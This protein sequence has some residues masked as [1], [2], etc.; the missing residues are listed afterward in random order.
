M[1]GLQ[2]HYGLEL[3]EKV[4]TELPSCPIVWG[5]VH[6]SLL[7][8]QTTASPY[9]DIVVRGEGEPVMAKLANNLSAGNRLDYVAGITY[10][11]AGEIKSNPECQPI[12][13]DSV[14]IELPFDLLPLDKYPSLRAGRF[15]IQTSRGCPHRCGYC[16]NTLFNKCGWRGKSA[17]RVL[18]EIEYILEKYPNVKTID[19][20]D[21]NFFADRKRAENICRGLIQRKINVTWRANCRFDYLSSYSRDFINLMEKSGCTELDF[22]GE[23]GSERLLT[24]IH[25]EITPTQMVQSVENLK[26]WA[27]T[28]K[29][30]VSWMSGLPTETDEDLKLTF[31]LMDR[32]SDV[33]P[34]TQHFGIFVFTPFPSPLV[35]SLGS[36]LKTPQS[37]EGWSDIDAFHFKPSW[38]S[39]K[40]V[41][42]LHAVSAVTRYAFFPSERIREHNI[43]FKIGYGFLNRTARFRWKS[44]YFG[45]PLELKLANTLAKKF[46]GWV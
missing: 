14:P 11:V 31:D 28:I 16:Y 5:G 35:E 40:Y 24:L 17:E 6:P 32:M 46:R 7:P 22:G 21:D 42:K 15:H 34:N 13:L 23:T 19:P 30:Y 18:D 1:S 43:S 27:P 25:K 26:N 33:N 12:D 29:P 38:H 39:K 41:E 4:R 36:Q 3:A 9:V 44:R 10:K 8:E 2:I 37:L 45:L 20:I